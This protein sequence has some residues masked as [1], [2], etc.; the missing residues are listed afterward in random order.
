MDTGCNVYCYV[1]VINS[2]CGIS[3]IRHTKHG[4]G[5]LCLFILSRP[6]DICGGETSG[7]LDEACM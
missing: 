2:V 4:R 1:L 7:V 6:V 3:I 5:V